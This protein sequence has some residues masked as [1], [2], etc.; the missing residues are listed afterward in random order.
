MPVIAVPT[1]EM[2]PVKCDNVSKHGT[3]TGKGNTKSFNADAEEYG[4][5]ERIPRQRR[6]YIKKMHLE[7]GECLLCI[8]DKSMEGKL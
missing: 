5:W 2:I 1:N 7:S 3:A 6:E 8:I 4:F